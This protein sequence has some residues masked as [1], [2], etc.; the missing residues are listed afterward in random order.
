M[1]FSYSFLGTLNMC[2]M[3]AISWPLFIMRT[4]GSPVLFAPL[5]MNPKYALYL[6]GVYFTFGSCATPFLLAA[7]VGLAPVFAKLLS[8]LRKR[9]KCPQWLAFFLL[10][11]L[12]AACYVIA[13]PVFITLACLA[14]HQ[15]VLKWFFWASRSNCCIIASC[16]RSMPLYAVCL[17]CWTRKRYGA[18]TWKM[19]WPVNRSSRDKEVCVVGGRSLVQQFST[20]ILACSPLRERGTVPFTSSIWRLAAAFEGSLYA[21]AHQWPECAAAWRVVQAVS[22]IL[23]CSVVGLFYCVLVSFAACQDEKKSSAG[24][25]TAFMFDSITSMLV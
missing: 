18:M 21:C 22:L 8:T 20:G 6:T 23:L 3:V 14:L 12:M 17:R 15:P 24:F 1:V 16:M 10:G 9:L 25:Y 4:G 11:L 19:N 7:A 5:K 13:L 2:M